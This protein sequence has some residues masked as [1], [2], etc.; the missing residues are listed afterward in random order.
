MT[1]PNPIPGSTPWKKGQSGNPKGRP[2]KLLRSLVL[3]L[4]N[5]GYERA[6]GLTV[7]EAF[8]VMLNLPEEEVK[9]LVADSSMPMSVRIVG[10]SMLSPKGFE[11][12]QTMMDR[13][14]GKAKQQVDMA[15]TVTSDTPTIIVQVM[16]PSPDGG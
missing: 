12:V 1:R 6:D 5:A 8:E 14:H 10:K 13:A 2:R 4:K 16:P 3:E 11:V 9:K 15:A 7:V